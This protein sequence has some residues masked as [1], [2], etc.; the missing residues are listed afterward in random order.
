MQLLLFHYHLHNTIFRW[1]E[2]IGR[3]LTGKCPA[4]LASWL[5]GLRRLCSVPAQGFLFTRSP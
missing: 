5:D 4:R 1:W 2:A 3:E